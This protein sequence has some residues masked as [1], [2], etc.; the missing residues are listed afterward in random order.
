MLTITGG[1]TLTVEEPDTGNLV[2]IATDRAPISPPAAAGSVAGCAA[3]RAHP[4]R[5]P[6][7]QA[8]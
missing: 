8:A 1:V 7:G 6:A 5:M 3:V 4:A 2:T